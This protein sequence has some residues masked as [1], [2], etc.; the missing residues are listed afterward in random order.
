MLRLPDAHAA[1]RML[2]EDRLGRA[3]LRALAARLASFHATAR[4]D[5]ETSSFGAVEV[6]EGNVRENFDQTRQSAPHYL[7]H[8]EVSDIERWQLDFL[9]SHRGRFERRVREGRVRDGHGD[10]RLEHCYFDPDGGVEVIDCIEFNE[11]FRYGDVCA[12][13]AFLAMDLSRH[14]RTDLA[15]AFLADYARASGDWDLYGLVDFYESYRA[16]VRAKVSSFLADDVD[17]PPEAR[18]Q[19]AEQAR[20]YYLLAEACTREALE[21]GALIAVGGVIASGKSSVAQ[22]LSASI[23][24]P[25][26]DADRT[27]K[28]LAGVGPDTPLRDGAFAGHYT[29]EATEQVYAELLRRAEVVLRSGRPVILDASF[30]RAAHR[31]AARALARRLGVPFRFGH[32][33]APMPVLRARLMRRAE[34]HSVSDG[35]EEILEDF[36]ARWE[37]CEELDAA[38]WVALDTR[39]DAD[40]AA[41]RLVEQ[42]PEQP[43]V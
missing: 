37:P 39:G 38:E 34:G 13:I 16:H 10:L 21:P 5:E 41:R 1:D 12:D 23:D 7:S 20:K 26:I 40:A 22:A 27:R 36:V 3:E 32:C 2:A 24:A 15:E 35:R 43:P 33:Q 4:C 42:L 17:A 8:R 6:I 25:V 28:Q 11:R 31:E 29:A 19:A 18:E 14:G 9:R 30:R